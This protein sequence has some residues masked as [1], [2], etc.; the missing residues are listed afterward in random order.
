MRQFEWPPLE[1]RIGMNGR[2]PLIRS[3]RCEGEVLVVEH[4]LRD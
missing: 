3:A 4:D 2:M 1:D